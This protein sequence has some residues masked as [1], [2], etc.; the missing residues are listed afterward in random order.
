MEGTPLT[1]LTPLTP[2]TSGKVTWQT[3]LQITAMTRI[4]Q[5]MLKKAPFMSRGHLYLL[6]SATGSSGI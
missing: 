2:F 4:S 3:A 6:L 1:P 5:G